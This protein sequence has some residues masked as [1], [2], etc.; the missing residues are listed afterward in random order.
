VAVAALAVVTGGWLVHRA[1]WPE[2]ALCVPAAVLLLY[3]DPVTI[4]VGMGILAVAVAVHLV[5]A[6]RSPTE[7][8]DQSHPDSRDT[9]GTS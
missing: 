4:A 5:T 8:P 3:L 2:R 6:R 9:A 7:S 1:R